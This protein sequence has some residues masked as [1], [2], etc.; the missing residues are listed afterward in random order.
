MSL[1][2]SLRGRSVTRS[3]VLSMIISSYLLATPTAEAFFSPSHPTSHTPLL[4]HDQNHHLQRQQHHNY[5]QQP[6]GFS[7]SSPTSP[8]ISTSS[9]STTTLLS[10]RGGAIASSIGALTST[11][12][13]TPKNFFNANLAGLALA[14][15]SIKIYQRTKKIHLPHRRRRR[16][17]TRQDPSHEIPPNPLPRRLL[18]PPLRRLAAGTVLLRNVRLEGLQR[19][20]GHPFHRF[21]PLS[22]RICVYRAV[23]SDCWENE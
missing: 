19:C 4:L 11:I 9:R 6:Q 7:P 2:T 8:K 18:A 14:T 3:I 23:W 5:H 20:S 12:T 10:M 13:S 1:T 15:A 16:T 22:H 21:Q 17:E